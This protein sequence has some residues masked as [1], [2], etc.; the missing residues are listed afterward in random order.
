MQNVSLGKKK[1]IVAVKRR[2]MQR[3]DKVVFVVVL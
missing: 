3:S 2:G 1:T